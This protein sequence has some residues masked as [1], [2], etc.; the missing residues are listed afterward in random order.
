VSV[1]RTHEDPRLVSPE[2][3]L[4][5]SP[6]DARNAQAQLPQRPSSSR[7]SGHPQE[8]EAAKRLALRVAGLVALIVVALGVAGY[9]AV[10][11]WRDS[12][13]SSGTNT[14]VPSRT[15][16]WAPAKGAAAY[17]VTFVRDGQ[18]VFQARAREPRVVIPRSFRFEPGNYRWTVRALPITSGAPALV[19][20]TFSLT[21]AGAS[22]A[23]DS[24]R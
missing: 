4:V 24:S 16:A 22:A 19:D 5:S 17:D 7:P 10:A 23:N 1:E 21:S 9:F 11:H 6:E 12:G 15:W 20:S 18:V 2:L 13:T 3:V 8:P 14:F